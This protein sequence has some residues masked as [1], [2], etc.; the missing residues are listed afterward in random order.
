MRPK[1]NKR[2]AFQLH[3]AL[4]TRYTVISEALR[5]LKLI[6]TRDK[7][8]LKRHLRVFSE[9]SGRNNINKNVEF[10]TETKIVTQVERLT[11]E[12]DLQNPYAHSTVM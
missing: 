3:C 12:R 9:H 1:N 4:V 7:S 6:K 10:K 5:T 2:V 8:T 11:N